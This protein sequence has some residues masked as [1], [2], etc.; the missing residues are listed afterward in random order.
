MFTLKSLLFIVAVAAIGAAGLIYRTQF[1]ASTLV[2]LTLAVLILAGCRAWFA[3]QVRAFWGPFTATGALYLA[4]VSLQPLQELHFN[5]PTTQLVVFGLDK[6]QTK[7]TASEAY[8]QLAGSA[9]TYAPVILP[10]AIVPNSTN[11]QAPLTFGYSYSSS[12]T[13]AAQSI[14]F[15]RPVLFQMATNYNSASGFPIQARAFLWV[16]QSLWCLLLALVAGLFCSWLFRPAA[17]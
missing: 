2:G 3:P 11:P 1:W 10:G 6:L 5:L 13:L 8:P 15:I 12:S 14:T 4:I 7:F 17:T 9:P 16:A